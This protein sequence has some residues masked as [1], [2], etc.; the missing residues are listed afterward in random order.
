MAITDDFT[1][2]P[3]GL[4][5]SQ[6]IIEVA[7]GQAE[8]CNVYLDQLFTLAFK[9]APDFSGSNDPE[10]DAR[11]VKFKLNRQVVDASSGEVK[12]ASVTVEAPLLALVP[13][14][15]FTMDEA[16]V[17]FTMEVKDSSVDTKTKEQKGGLEGSFSVWGFSAKISG[18]VTTDISQTRSTDKSAKYEIYAR[19]AQQPAA[20]GMAKLST[21]FASVIEP[22]T[23]GK[24]GS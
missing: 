19:A 21:I 23:T 24:S 2:I 1:G 12:T 17:R 20:E 5:V 14:P 4:L 22:I 13:I 11:V 10:V 3:L 7:K 16:T 8:L 6:P 9:T 18:S 15:A